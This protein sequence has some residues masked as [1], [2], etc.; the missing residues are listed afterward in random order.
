M[1]GLQ[2]FFLQDPI[3]DGDPTT[4]DGIF[5]LTSPAASLPDP[6][7][8]AQVTGKVIEQTRDGKPGSVTEIDAT[9]GSVDVTGVAP[10]PEPVVLDPGLNQP[11]NP[12]AAVEGMLVQYPASTVVTPSDSTGAYF[13]LRDD[14]LPDGSRVTPDNPGTG[15]PIMIDTAGGT[16]VQNLNELDTAPAMTGVLH[17][18]QGAYRLQPLAPYDGASTGI[19][20]KPAPNDQP[21]LNVAT[22]DAMGLASG[23]PADQRQT[24]IAKL[25]LAIQNELGS[26]ELIAVTRI[27]DI[28]SILDVGQAA[29]NYFGLFVRGCSP[30]GTST[31][32]LFN[33]ERILPV[34]S[35]QFNLDSPQFNLPACTLLNGEVFAHPLFETPLLQVDVAV[36]QAVGVTLII[37]DWRSAATDTA[38]Q[39]RVGTAAILAMLA[40]TN[41]ENIIVLGNFNQPETSS[42]LNTLESS[43]NFTNLSRGV[44]SATRYTVTGDGVSQAVDHIFLS[45]PLK[46]VLLST[47]F[48]H[49]NADFSV[50]PNR[51]DPG[52]AIRASDHDSAFAHLQLF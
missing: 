4:S 36:D 12:L 37:A 44:E 2:G 22:L 3:G 40:R 31:G 47:G 5:V 33:M 41:A 34:R 6:G 16:L 29:G 7:S 30:D 25:A 52:T 18:D 48:A 10:L 13:A 20:A 11:S 45:Q 35:Q 15:V 27:G 50:A 42:A 46:S 19:A 9:A 14:R 38:N 8:M 39:A 24:L 43:G 1:G 23:M 21:Y 17:F 51:N 49:Y 28:K 32:L 26:P